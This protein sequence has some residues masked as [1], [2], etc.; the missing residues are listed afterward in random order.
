MVFVMTKEQA[1]QLLKENNLRVTAPRVA[2]LCVFETAEKPLSHTEVLECLGESDWDQATVYR[3]LIKLRD[4]GLLSVVS[5]ANGID[6]YARSLSN[7]G[8]HQ[9]PH[10]YCNDCGEVSCLPI[11]LVSSTSDQSRWSTSVKAAS[12]QLRGECPDCI[13]TESQ[14]S[15]AS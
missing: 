12:I 14:D 15:S 2:V 10:F 6:R 9:H 8:S 5:Q 7:G 4:E 11:E 1:R 13:D 3:N